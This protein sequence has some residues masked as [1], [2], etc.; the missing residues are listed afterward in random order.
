MLSAVICCY[1]D[2]RA[3]PVM[4]QRLTDVFRSLQT[5][6]EIIFVNDC[7]P[8]DA[9]SVLK[10]LTA[11]DSHVLA[12]E[13]SRNFGSQNAFVS[14]MQLATGDAVILLD[15]DLQDPPELIAAFHAKW[16]EGYDVVYGRRVR[17]E[18]SALLALLAKAFYRVFRGL[19]T[20]IPGRATL[21]DGSEGVNEML[22]GRRTSSYGLRAGR[23]HA[24]GRRHVRRGRA[25]GSTHSSMKNGG[26]KKGASRHICSDRTTRVRGSPWPLSVGDV[27]TNSSSTPA[28]EPHSG[29]GHTSLVAFFGSCMGRDSDNRR[30][31]SRSWEQSGPKF[32]ARLC[33]RRKAPGQRS[34]NRRIRRK[35]IPGVPPRKLRPEPSERSIREPRQASVENCTGIREKWR[36]GLA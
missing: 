21:P 28:S 34:R 11:A 12:I 26:G 15:G 36:A 7:S 29:R 1:Q 18:G 30:T 6:Y 3:I 17:R 10:D 4:H 9:D 35:P 25:L 23:F 19:S 5:P 33:A 8:D 13:H 31:W 14:G 32:I 22:A 24:G 27:V 16:K 20:A 2:A